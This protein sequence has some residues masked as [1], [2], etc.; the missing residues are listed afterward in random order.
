[1]IDFKFVFRGKTYNAQY[2]AES[3]GKGDVIYV[4]AEDAHLA[5]IY[6]PHHLFLRPHGIDSVWEYGLYGIEDR[7]VI[8][9]LKNAIKV[10]LIKETEA[11]PNWTPT[12]F[13]NCSLW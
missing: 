9:E 5:D 7:E 3:L 2:Y 8:H 10:G 4:Y 13:L 12:I 11:Q 6:G 1:M